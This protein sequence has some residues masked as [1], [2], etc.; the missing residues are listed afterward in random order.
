MHEKA[1]ARRESPERGSLD[2][3]Y[4]VGADAG[5]D[6]DLLVALQQARIKFAVGVNLPL[7]DIVLYASF[8]QI[9]NILA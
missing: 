1:A 5:G 6:V 9:E 2:H 4:V 3:K 7:Q 8:L